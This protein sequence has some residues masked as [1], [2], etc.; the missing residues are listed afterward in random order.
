MDFQAQSQ[1]F[2]SFLSAGSG[3]SGQL[4]RGDLDDHT[5]FQPITSE[6]LDTKNPEAAE[7]FL[8]SLKHI[9]LGGTK[10]VGLTNQGDLYAWGEDSEKLGEVRIIYF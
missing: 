4:L 1:S 8:K 3:G 9:A 10:A 5:T 2:T 7:E 6:K